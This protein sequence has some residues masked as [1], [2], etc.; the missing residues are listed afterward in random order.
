LDSTV[1]SLKASDF[2]PAASGGLGAGGQRTFTFQ[3][4]HAGTA[5]LNF[6]L[7][8]QWQGE[9]APPAERFTVTIRVK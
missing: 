7:K 2:T 6:L 1:L 8:R 3:P 5:T 4:R 9:T